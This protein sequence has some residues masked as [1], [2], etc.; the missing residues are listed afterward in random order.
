M[1]MNIDSMIV[2][3]VLALAVLL[4][5]LKM[6]ESVKKLHKDNLELY[7]QMFD[8]MDTDNDGQITGEEFHAFLEKAHEKDG[9]TQEEIKD[10]LTETDVNGDENFAFDDFLAVLGNQVYQEPEND[11][12]VAFFQR[13][14]TNNTNKI[15]KDEL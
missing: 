1:V 7:K 2:F 4:E 5:T 10:L 15:T 3:R 13:I 11:E 14:D 8:L 9:L 12:L 6:A